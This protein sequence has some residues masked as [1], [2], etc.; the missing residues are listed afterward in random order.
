VE[1]TN[2]MLQVRD[3]YAKRPDY[4]GR[5]RHSWQAGAYYTLGV[6]LII[7]DEQGRLSLKVQGIHWAGNDHTVMED[8]EKPPYPSEEQLRP[9]RLTSLSGMA[10]RS[11]N[12]SRYWRCRLGSMKS[13]P[14]QGSC[15]HLRMLW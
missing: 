8:L 10:C 11:P 3:D 1:H 5:M 14:H 9:M 6:T 13:F 2:H 7:P 4:A 15:S 12:G